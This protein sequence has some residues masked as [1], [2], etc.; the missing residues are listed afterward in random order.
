[1]LNGCKIHKNVEVAGLALQKLIE[2]EPDNYA[3]LYA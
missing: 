2:L 1:M 3:N